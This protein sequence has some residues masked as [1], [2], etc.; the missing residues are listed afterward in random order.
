MVLSVRLQQDRERTLPGFGT[1]S[2]VFGWISSLLSSPG[3]CAGPTGLRID[4]AA[5]TAPQPLAGFW[6]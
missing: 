6:L 1:T 4:R 2:R 5:G 3:G